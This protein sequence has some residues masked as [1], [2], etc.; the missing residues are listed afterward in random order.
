[1]IIEA[2]Q[3]A[4]YEVTYAS[5]TKTIEEG[6]GEIEKSLRNADANIEK[7]ASLFTSTII[8]DAERDFIGDWDQVFAEEMQEES[9][10]KG[11][12]NIT[13]AEPDQGITK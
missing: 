6:I 13:R 11:G 9:A 12:P 1:M 3:K 8:V 10:G 7:A 5:A 4:G 2:L